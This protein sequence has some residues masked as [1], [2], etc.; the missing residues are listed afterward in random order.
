MTFTTSSK[1]WVIYKSALKRLKWFGILYGVALVLELPLLL[2][3]QLGRL[4][5]IQGAAWVANK[6]FQPRMLFNPETHLTNIAVAIIFGLI[7]FYYL[8]NDRANTFFHSLP[9]KRSSLYC[10]NLLAGLT[11]MWL[12]LLLN[13]L[14]VYLVFSFFGITEGQWNN[15]QV[16]G[17]M[18]ELLNNT[19]I[20]VSIGE[21]L[22]FLIFLSLLMTGLFFIFTVFIGMLTGNVLLQG[23][24]TFIGLFLPLGIYLLVN[25]NLAKL[26]YGFPRDLNNKITQWSSPVVNYLETTNYGFTAGQIKWYLGY[27]AVAVI[28]TGISIY[29]YKQRHAEAA[30]ETLA[31]A[32]IRWVFKYG[33]ALCAALVGGIYF[34]A[35]NEDSTGVLYLGYFLGAFLGYSISDMIAY[36]SF[37]F[38]KRWKG[39]AVFGIV[40]I[41]LLG[42]VRFD[43]VGY[44]RYVPAQDDVKSVLVSN[45]A[46]DGYLQVNGELNIQGMTTPENIERVRILHRQIVDNEEV[47]KN[48]ERSVRR[49]QN[50]PMQESESIEKPE[51]LQRRLVPLTLVYVLQN[52]SRVTRTYNIDVNSYRQY[53]YPIFN[54]PEAKKTMFSRYFQIDTAKLDHIGVNNFH[55]G[56]DVRIYHRN[57]MDEALTALR[58]D[59]LNISYEEAVEGKLPST[60]SIDLFVKTGMNGG[61]YS[62][63]LASYQSFSNF[64]NFLK[65]HGYWDTLFLKPEEISQ[66]IIKK[67][68]KG[69]LTEITDKQKIQSLLN[70]CNLADERTFLMKQTD[71]RMGKTGE[72]VGK[73]ELKNGKTIF[74]TFN[75]SLYDRQQVKQ[76]I[77]R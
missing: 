34:S 26:L 25:E 58:Q 14:L 70:L 71:P 62:Y 43:L 3:M 59:L 33:V 45:L 37:H 74:V 4:K 42:A 35:L 30:G 55:L 39:M 21:I 38:Y 40:F 47:N 65:Q 73:I 12:P 28:L 63:S 29:L 20:T 16:Y 50:Q 76:I 56:R 7:I 57:E 51:L 27:L 6:S 53:L 77:A 68:D 64:E 66:I 48:M 18:G 11:L 31:A 8:H 41:L 10:Q 49:L 52:G 22:G 32:W 17:F 67:I 24:L 2:W 5:D 69:T 13:G 19:P 46:R 36:K 75:G 61:Y 23:V 15:P 44:E 60:A 1:T 9:I 72:Y 54:T